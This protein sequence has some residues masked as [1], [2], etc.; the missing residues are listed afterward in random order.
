VCVCF[1]KTFLIFVLLN[2][3][4]C[5]CCANNGAHRQDSLWI[6]SNADVAAFH[7]PMW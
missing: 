4:I 6:S 5:V 1:K 7:G 2:W 3:S